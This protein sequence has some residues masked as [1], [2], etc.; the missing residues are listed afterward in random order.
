MESCSRCGATRWLDRHH[1]LP[2]SRGGDDSD[3][4]VL[5]RRCHEWVHRHPHLAEEEGLYERGIRLRKPRGGTEP[6][7]HA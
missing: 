7:A 2:R 6:E 3:V 1:V 5:C 4:V